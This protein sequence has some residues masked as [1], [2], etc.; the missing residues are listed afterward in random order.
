MNL[1]NNAKRNKNTVVTLERGQSGKWKE[2]PGEGRHKKVLFLDLGLGS[3][4]MNIHAA[5]H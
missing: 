4:S 3:E 2:D 1:T 5:V